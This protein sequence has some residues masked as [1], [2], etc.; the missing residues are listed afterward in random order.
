MQPLLHL[1]TSAYELYQ[2]LAA[3]DAA[4]FLGQNRLHGGRGGG[5]IQDNAR[6]GTGLMDGLHTSVKMRAD[7]AV[8]TDRVGPGCHE[9]SHIAIRGLDHQMDVERQIG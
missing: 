6:S 3:F 4:K 9:V 2:T 7:F 8:D 5:G 1:A